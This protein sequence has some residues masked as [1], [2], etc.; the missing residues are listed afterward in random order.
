MGIARYI[1]VLRRAGRPRPRLR[2]R[3][4]RRQKSRVHQ[5]RGDPAI[6]RRDR[7]A[8][9]ER[10][11]SG[12]ARGAAAAAVVGSA[13][14][15][16]QVFRHELA[17]RD[18]VL[19][20]GHD[21]AP[22]GAVR[23]ALHADDQRAVSRR[24]AGFRNALRGRAQRVPR[25]RAEMARFVRAFRPEHHP[26]RDAQPAS[27]AAGDHRR[28]AAAEGS[29]VALCRPRAWLDGRGIRPQ[30]GRREGRGHSGQGLRRMGQR[31]L[32]IRGRIRAG[33]ATIWSARRCSTATRPASRGGRSATK[34][35]CCPG[36]RR[37]RKFS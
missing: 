34:G 14:V 5:V 16:D 17:F 13:P 30:N 28:K 25:H 29:G 1:G 33:R 26:A 23:A 12:A 6:D 10:R 4:L 27:A 3:F 9:P 2:C 19:G 37:R 32:P 36:R 8:P 18:L 11:T 24:A 15:S 7:A 31:L 22:V 21:R 20:R 35:C